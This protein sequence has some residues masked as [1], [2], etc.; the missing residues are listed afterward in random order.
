MAT[1]TSSSPSRTITASRVARFT[2]T[3]VREGWTANIGSDQCE[4]LHRDETAALKCGLADPRRFQPEHNGLLRMVTDAPMGTL[5]VQDTEEH[6]PQVLAVCARP[7]SARPWSTISG[8][9][10]A[11]AEVVRWAQAFTGTL[12]TVTVSLEA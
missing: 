12:R 11:A 5:L 7:D 8:N 1:I 2:S 6:G 10:M 9:G 4:H 3:G